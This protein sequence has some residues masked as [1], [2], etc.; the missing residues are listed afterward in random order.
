VQLDIEKDRHANVLHC[1]D[2]LMTG[3]AEKLE[4]NFGNTD[5]CLDR[6][7]YGDGLAQIRGV[8]SNG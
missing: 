5:V 4:P 7:S 3:R 8:K 2:C 1:P 6:L